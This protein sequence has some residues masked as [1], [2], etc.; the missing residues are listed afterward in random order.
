MNLALNRL[1]IQ[2]S[3]FCL[4]GLGCSLSF[5]VKKWNN[6]LKFSNTYKE[7]K[8]KRLKEDKL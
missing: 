4:G 5:L 1:V 3:A 8:P 6:F 2:H 7:N